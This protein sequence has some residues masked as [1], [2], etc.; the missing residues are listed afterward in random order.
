VPPADTYES[1]LQFLYRTPI[2]MVQSS[3]DGDVEMI[4]PMAS[5]LLMPLSRDGSLDNIFTV[6]EQV[7]PQLR[8][9]VADADCE[10][11]RIVLEP[12]PGS[13]AAPQVLSIGVLAIDDGR[14]MVV[15]H[16][17]SLEVQREQ[18]DRAHGLRVATHTDRLTQLPN[19][20]AVLEHL[21]LQ[22]CAQ[23]GAGTGPIP[24]VLFVNCDR[25]HQINDMLGPAVG[26]EL[27]A[28]LAQRLRSLGGVQLAARVGGDE[29]VVVLDP[30]R[31]PEDV[32]A[33][34]RRL[35]G[36]SAMP[37]GIA[38]RQ[39]QASV[40]I[41]VAMGAEAT[42][43]PDV[44]LRNA[45]IAMVEAKRAGGARYVVFEPAMHERAA[46]RGGVETE[47]RVAIAEDQLF[48]VY[49][50]VVS[51]QGRAD[52]GDCAGVEALVRW[53]HPTRGVVPPLEFIGVAEECGLIGALGSFVLATACHQFVR[54][55]RELGPRAP[56]MLA[57][58][59]SRAQ[60]HV[61][62]YVDEVRETLRASG[63]NPERLQ[64]EVTESLA[65]QDAVV[66]LRLQE[67]KALGL[68]LALDD[69]GT[70]YSSLSSLHLLP[71]DTVKI[72][73]SFV[74]RADSSQ[75][76]RVLI[77]ATVRVAKSLGMG[78]VAEGIETTAQAE[79]VRALGC[80]KGQGYLFSKPLAADELGRWLGDQ[81]P[82]IDSTHWIAEGEPHLRELTNTW[83]NTPSS[84]IT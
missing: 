30:Q 74:S 68:T 15:V 1:L 53:R 28:T 17:V 13:I 55:Q 4:N 81:R 37:Y 32:H 61:P 2:G 39:L 67:L 57:V 70:G 33:I 48:V 21:Q 36:V 10:A 5:R 47:L 82:T 8:T 18:Q 73:R 38:S 16:D 11:L 79:T 19:R 60:L 23:P 24:A 34:A 31:E 54:W 56:A 65:A 71:V 20:A 77:D 42:G 25:F 45:S 12:V 46:R 22:A 49:Q 29:F 6:L 75:H 72:D 78:T 80:D 35:L 9:L 14:L 50:P 66:Q 58:N 43:D 41:G 63:M 51:L 7:A 44:V 52:P 83:R 59:V 40:S 26:D 84:S 76:H 27:L 69:F 3:A 62:E 64:L